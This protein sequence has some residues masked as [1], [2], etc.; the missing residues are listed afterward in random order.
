MVIVKQGEVL[1]KTEGRR[2]VEAHEEKGKDT[3]CESYACTGTPN[4][5]VRKQKSEE[6][7]MKR[8]EKGKC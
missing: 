8:G 2:R 3:R 5:F 4:F 1:R 7:Y 6:K